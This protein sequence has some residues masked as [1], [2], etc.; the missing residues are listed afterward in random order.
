MENSHQTFCSEPGTPAG[1][2]PF[3]VIPSYW[4]FEGCGLSLGLMFISWKKKIKRSL[5]FWQ[6]KN[7]FGNSSSKFSQKGILVYC[8]A[9]IT[10]SKSNVQQLKAKS[11]SFLSSRQALVYEKN[12][13]VQPFSIMHCLCRAPCLQRF[14]LDHQLFQS[15]IKKYLLLLGFNHRKCIINS[16]WQISCA[17]SQP[18]PLKLKDFVRV[19]GKILQSKIL[20]P[21]EQ[22]KPARLPRCKHCSASKTP[23]RNWVWG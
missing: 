12:H 1:S 19:T 4:L 5:S 7:K 8:P 11:Y 10:N 13:R 16:M 14:R 20:Y 22:L 2:L 17:P 9:L 3:L 15:G 23:I 6:N 18:T 21:E